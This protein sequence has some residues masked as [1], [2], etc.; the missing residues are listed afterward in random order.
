MMAYTEIPRRDASAVIRSFVFQVN[1]TIR[2]WIEL[3][4][5]SRLVVVHG[6]DIDTAQDGSVE[7]ADAEKRLLEQLKVRDTRAL[8]LRSPDAL[9][10]V[11]NYCRHRQNNPEVDLQFRYVTPKGLLQGYR[12]NRAATKAES[13]VYGPSMRQIRRLHVYAGKRVENKAAK[14]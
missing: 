14:G 11:A 1:L 13:R 6:V 9:Q 4:A 5:N 10:S 8:T 2:R 7:G 12:G 3:P